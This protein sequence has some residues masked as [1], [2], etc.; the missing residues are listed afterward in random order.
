MTEG[1][2]LEFVNPPSAARYMALALLPKKGTGG[3]AHPSIRAAW[4]GLVPSEILPPA[5]NS[6]ITN[7]DRTI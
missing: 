5:R 2:S 3:I 1:I 6:L 7:V 4:R